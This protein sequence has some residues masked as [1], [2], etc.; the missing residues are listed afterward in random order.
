MPVP[1]LME[2]LV[3]ILLCPCRTHV[4]VIGRERTCFGCVQAAHRTKNGLE[5]HAELG[6]HLARGTDP[7]ATDCTANTT[8]GRL[9]KIH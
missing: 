1:W 9:Q 7:N 2:V 4:L 5:L 6:I 8:V 3:S